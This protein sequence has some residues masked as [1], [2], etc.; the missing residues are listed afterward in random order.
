MDYRI[1]C[2]VERSAKMNKIFVDLDNESMHF[3]DDFNDSVEIDIEQKK[4]SK[5]VGN[6]Q[7]SKGNDYYDVNTEV[8]GNSKQWRPTDKSPYDV[9]ENDD[10]AYERFCDDLEDEQ[11]QVKKMW[12]KEDISPYDYYEDYDE[13]C[14]KCVRASSCEC[15]DKTPMMP[16]FE[17][18]F[19]AQDC[20]P[21]ADMYDNN[22]IDCHC[23][24]ASCGDATLPLDDT[25]TCPCPKIITIEKKYFIDKRE[26]NTTKT[27]CWMKETKEF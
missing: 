20:Y 19:D 21:E 22:N 6:T 16:Q 9:M 24:C 18:D 5:H 25:G 17:E 13:P 8:R 7:S 2:G 27:Y 26:D 14:N 11:A 12:H 10:F 23:Q 4:A 15:V 1:V 3:L